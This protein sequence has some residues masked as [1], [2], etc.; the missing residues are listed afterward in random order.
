MS[1]FITEHNQER[2]NQIGPLTPPAAKGYVLTSAASTNPGAGAKFIRVS[3][4]AASFLGIMAS[5][6]APLGASN[7]FR[8]PAN[9]PPELFYLPTTAS[10]IMGAST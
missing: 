1:L 7:A 10:F 8:I 3:A 6:T 5:T 9:A 4:D 2:P